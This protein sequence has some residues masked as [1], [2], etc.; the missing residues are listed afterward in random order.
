MLKLAI[1][2]KTLDGRYGELVR[3]H[4]ER[5]DAE[6]HVLHTGY[7][8]AFVNDS[9]YL[10]P[11]FDGTKGATIFHHI[12]RAPKFTRLRHEIASFLKEKQIDIVLAEYG[13]TGIELGPICQELNIPLIVQFFG[14]DAYRENVMYWYGSKFRRMF[15]Q[16]TWLMVTSQAMKERLVDL[17]AS[18]QKIKYNPGGFDETSISKGNPQENPPVFLHI[19][20][21]GTAEG[22]EYTAEAFEMLYEK[23]PDAKLKFIGDG[24]LR[25]ITEKEFENR[26]LKGKAV[27][28]L[29]DLDPQDLAEELRNARGLFFPGRTTA[30]NDVDGIPLP[31]LKGLGAG[32]PIVAT[33]FGGTEDVVTD[34]K[35]GF[36][37]QEQDTET[38]ARMLGE[39]AAD[40]ALAQQMGDSGYEAVKEEFTLSAHLSRLQAAIAECRMEK[41]LA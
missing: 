15:K 33:T 32:L 38:M 24:P 28:F 36:I 19:S 8:P 12:A 29:G 7:L 14:F 40:P 39:L 3:A 10:V 41:A 35:N 21:F 27:E 20:Q 13:P 17:G 26:N 22:P 31:I 23:H 4:I 18:P 25:M 30:N 2:A 16:A 6:V 11:G 37:V 34:G 1:A 9:Q 5:L